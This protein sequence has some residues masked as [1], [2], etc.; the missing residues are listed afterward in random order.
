MA[1]NRHN[2]LQF[3]VDKSEPDENCA[4]YHTLRS[5]N[6]ARAVVVQVL[7]RSGMATTGYYLRSNFLQTCG[8]LRR[9][10]EN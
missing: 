7:I 1:V 2:P 6:P 3:S 9:R 4:E 8:T 5:V 10:S